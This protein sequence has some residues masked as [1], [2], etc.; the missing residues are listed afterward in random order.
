[1]VVDEK[2]VFEVNG[3][4]QHG[5][6]NKIYYGNKIDMVK[7]ET[8]QGDYTVPRNSVYNKEDIRQKIYKN[9]LKIE[10]LKDVNC[11]LIAIQDSLREAY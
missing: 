6:V 3:N 8:S 5:I 2:V 7:I 4:L 11:K 1:M 9:K 10:Q